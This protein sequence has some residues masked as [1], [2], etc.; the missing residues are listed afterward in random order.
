MKK[1][2]GSMPDWDD[3]RYFLEVART[4]RASAAAARL[5]VE[6]TTVTRRI[7]HLEAALGQPLFEKS[8]T[9]G[10]TLTRSG[11]QFLSHAEQMETHLYNAQEQIQGVSQ[12]PSGHVRV[13]ATEAFGACVI[14]PLCAQFQ[15]QYPDMTVDVLPVPRFVSLTRREADIAIT[16][17]RPARGPYVTRKLTDY[18][19]LLYGTRAYFDRYGGIG[20]VADLRRHRFISYVD[21]LLFSE[22]LRYLED[23]LPFTKPVIKSTSV[24]A[25]Y[26]S[27]LQGHGLAILP[28]FLAGQN[29]QLVPILQD[30]IGIRRSFWIYY[31]EELKRLKR[32]VMLSEHL[33]DIIANH[34]LLVEG[35]IPVQQVQ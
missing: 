12:S 29:P 13:A 24:I 5:G 32:I 14:A 28:C 19:L 34:P 4:Q 10:F 16:I 33:C 8:R 6:H 23:I 15:S 18:T 9:S 20:D 26:Y 21:E 2:P 27:C 35:G 30:R 7:R 1:D 22:Q 3:I 25:Q 11:Q 31:H 17:E